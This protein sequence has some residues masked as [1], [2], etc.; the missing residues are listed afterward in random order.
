[1]PHQ[2]TLIYTESLLRQAVF[3]FWRRS[4]GVGL[5]FAMLWVAASLAWLV[6]RG[7]SSWVVG[8]LAS[9]LVVAVLL[10]ATVYAV[11][12]RNAFA[13][14][15]G[16]P[17]MQAELVA[18]ET[19]FTVTSELGSS[20]LPWSSVTE[21]WRF[22]SCWLLLFSKAQFITLPLACVPAEMQGFIE[23][24]V[25]VTSAA[26]RLASSAA[27]TKDWVASDYK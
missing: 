5:P 7:D 26:S 9:V 27:G 16:M 12:Y 23:L 11:H 25:A 13:K 18:D 17:S 22:E 3:N 19:G 10:A 6:W 21:I 20:T 14:L 1:M 24:R 2:T 4:I 8:V 15:H